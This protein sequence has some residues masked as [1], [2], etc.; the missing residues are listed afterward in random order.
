MQKKRGGT[1]VLY[2]KSA[3]DLWENIRVPNS[4]K[5][6]SDFISSYTNGRTMPTWKCYDILT[7]LHDFEQ[8]PSKVCNVIL[9]RYY[10]NHIHL[11]DRSNPE[12]KKPWEVVDKFLSSGQ[13]ISG[14][15]YIDFSFLDSDSSPIVESQYTELIEK[16]EKFY[17]SVV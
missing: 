9:N 11:Y 17:N 8:Y 5:P 13:S 3:V 12:I 7:N 2:K 4:R 6:E 10:R 15:E 14:F 16:Y 1:P